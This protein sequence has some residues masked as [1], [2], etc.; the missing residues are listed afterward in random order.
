[1]HEEKMSN[2]K[3]TNYII[4]GLAGGYLLYIAY[5]LFTDFASV[6]ENNRMIIILAMVLFSIIGLG[7]LFFS[8][9]SFI[10]IQKEI[11][12]EESMQEGATSKEDDD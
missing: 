5:S 9:R 6:P 1:M 7:L 8:V 10:K 12:T 3:R 4:R 2:N 11:D